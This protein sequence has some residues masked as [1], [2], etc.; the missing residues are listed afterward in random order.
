MGTK[1]Q[2][3]LTD[4]AVATLRHLSKRDQVRARRVTN[5][6]K[7]LGNSGPAYPSLKSHKIDSIKG[8]FG[9]TWESYVENHTPNAW[10][11]FWCYGPTE[12]VLTVFLIR[13]H[14]P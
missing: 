12:G 5:A 4:E 11:I 13:E 10:R 1:F 2:V 3:K 6:L 7:K 9:E 8:P 14:L